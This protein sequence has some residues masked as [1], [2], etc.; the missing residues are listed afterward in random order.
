MLKHTTHYS[1][2]TTH[3]SLLTTHYSQLTTHYS[4]LTTHYSLLPTHY[5][6]LEFVYLEFFNIDG[7]NNNWYRINWWI[8]GALPSGERACKP[9]DW[10]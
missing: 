1:P 7:N 4:L 5:S 6:L 2:L 10:R 9:G 3:H 8:D